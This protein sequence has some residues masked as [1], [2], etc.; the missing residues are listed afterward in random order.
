MMHEL[1]FYT[2]HAIRHRASSFRHLLSPSG[3]PLVS[4]ATRGFATH[5]F[6]A[7]A[8]FI[9]SS[10]HSVDNEQTTKD[11]KTI[12]REFSFRCS[13][14]CDTCAILSSLLSF[15]STGSDSDG[16]LLHKTKETECKN[17]AFGLQFNRV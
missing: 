1:C 11:L 2:F 8:L 10:R 4:F 7:R 6:I 5:S 17:D 16:C 14:L 12:P 3:G 9:S 15:C 13:V